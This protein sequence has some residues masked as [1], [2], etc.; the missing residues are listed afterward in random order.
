LIDRE[1][2]AKLTRIPFASGT[3]PATKVQQIFE[4]DII[5]SFAVVSLTGE[6]YLSVVNHLAQQNLTGGIIFDSRRTV[7]RQQAYIFVG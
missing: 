1:L 7:C 3:L 5:S 6:D 4:T 2:Y